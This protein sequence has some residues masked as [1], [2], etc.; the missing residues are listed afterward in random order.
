MFEKTGNPGKIG[1][2][3][4]NPELVNRRFEQQNLIAGLSN[5]FLILIYANP[6]LI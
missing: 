4:L 2:I 6:N 3:C 5:Q 1:K